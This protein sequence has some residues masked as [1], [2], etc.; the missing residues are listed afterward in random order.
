MFTC[1]SS[2]VFRANRKANGVTQGTQG[3]RSEFTPGVSLGGSGVSIGGGDGFLGYYQSNIANCVFFHQSD[4]NI[5][6]GPV[7]LWKSHS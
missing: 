7:P 1:G 5:I 4:L 3:T 6:K 2:K